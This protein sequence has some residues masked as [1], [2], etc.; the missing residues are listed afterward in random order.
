MAKSLARRTMLKAAG[1]SLALPMLDAMQPAFAKADAAEPPKRFVGIMTNMGILP[2]YFFPEE[3]GRDYT[4]SPYLDI[5]KDHRKDLTVFSGVSLPGVD[6]GH[7]AEKSFL[8][9][10]PGASRGSFKNSISLDQVMAEKVGGETRFPSLA[11]MVGA[12]MMSCSWTRSGSMIPPQRSPLKLYQQLFVED[13]AEGKASALRHLQED[14]SLLDS[15]REKSSRLAKRVG[16]ADR[17]RQIG[18]AHV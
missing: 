5:L 10:A 6:G 4:P 2:Q 13:S 9:G 18:R 14:R 12:E 15:L 17:E 7:A 8:T 1:V 11:L 3:A 16:A